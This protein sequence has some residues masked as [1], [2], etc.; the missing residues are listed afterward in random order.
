MGQKFLISEQERF[1]IKK[2]YGLITEAVEPY[3][4]S[5]R[6][7]FE[8]GYYGPSYAA[9]FLDPIIE[10]IKNY[11]LARPGERFVVNVSISS[12]ESQIP[13]T[14]NEGVMTGKAGTPLAPKQLAIQRGI[15]IRDYLNEKLGELVK[16]GV[17]PSLPQYTIA[18]PKIG[19]TPWVGTEFCP[20]GSTDAQQRGVCKE[21][22]KTCCGK[23]MENAS[24]YYDNYQ[25]EQYLDMSITITEETPE[26]DYG[27]C[28]KGFRIRVFVPKHNCQNAEFFVFA[29]SKLLY[30]SVGGMTANL[31]NIYASRGI[32]RGK[33]LPLFYPEALNPGYGFLKNGDGK[34]GSYKF[35]NKVLFNERNPKD[36]GDEGGG[37]SDTFYVTAEESK[38]ML[39]E[40]SGKINLWL[41]GTTDTTH[42]DIN[43]V[44]IYDE[45][46]NLPFYN[47]QPKFNQG[48]LVTI[49]FDT[50]CRRTVITNT[51]NSVPDVTGWI[52]KLKQEKISVMAEVDLMGLR[53][54]GKK[55]QEKRKMITDSKALLGERV[56][57]LLNKMLDLLN[58][59]YDELSKSA[60][61]NGTVASVSNDISEK[62]K[63][64]YSGFSESLNY[65]GTTEKPEMVLSQ[66]P[67][68]EYTNKTLRNDP[69]FGDIRNRM[70]Q[71]YE[72]F[73]ILY[74]KSS[75]QAGIRK[76]DGT[77][78]GTI[79][80]NKLKNAKQWAFNR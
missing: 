14:D 11:L 70:N 9:Q 43:F 30:N 42:D 10:N 59:I 50:S 61:K 63:N 56:G 27:K 26:I 16:T 77:I 68:G 54:G 21:K 44:S 57:E 29:N 75:G 13:N 31:N 46:S 48:K 69:L 19:A 52:N 53:T 17:L 34:Y 33:S 74:T 65:T 7:T 15:T 23:G 20:E 32:P 22:Y 6:V 49:S 72:G 78:D 41:I 1:H 60:D 62:I 76:K 66:L 45:N 71:F 18:D 51:D 12:G 64:S 38:Q 36:T 25:K 3:T 40:G 2:L 4:Q 47:K 55:T 58:P 28:A 35:G 24:K 5:Q 73:N 67:T 37:R 79:L 80:L 8:A 39:I